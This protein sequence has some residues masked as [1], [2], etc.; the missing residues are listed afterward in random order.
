[1][2]AYLPWVTCGTGL[3]L[4]SLSV[5]VAERAA[6]DLPLRSARTRTA[7]WLATSVAVGGLYLVGWLRFGATSMLATWCWVCSL[8]IS[9]A[10][11]DLYFRRLPFA[12]VAAFGAG[13][14]ATF[15]AAAVADGRW[16][17]LAFA[18][19]AAAAVFAAA[20]AVQMALPDHTGGG[21]TA[22]YGVLALYLGWFGWAGLFRGLLI[23]SGLT[24][25]VGLVVAACSGCARTRFPAGPSLLA[26]AFASVL[27]A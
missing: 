20:V 6:G 9:L 19:G 18:C 8:G 2:A 14:A 7:V 15:L 27:L 21:D 17:R 16:G 26:G 24:A 13:G 22:L 4:G 11:A 25:V 5:L 23:A 3:L 12:L 1:M 10:L